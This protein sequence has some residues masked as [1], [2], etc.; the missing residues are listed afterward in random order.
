MEDTR[1][2]SVDSMTTMLATGVIAL[3]LLAPIS[4]QAASRK[5]NAGALFFQASNPYIEECQSLDKENP[6]RKVCSDGSI[7]YIQPPSADPNGGLCVSTALA[8]LL[9]NMGC[10]SRPT[11]YYVG[12]VDPDED[13]ANM[14]RVEVVADDVQHLHGCDL[15][16]DKTEATIKNIRYQLRTWIDQPRT[17]LDINPVVISL[18]A[19]GMRHAVTVVRVTDNTRRGCRVWVNHW[20]RQ[21]GVSCEIFRAWIDGR[22]MVFVAGRE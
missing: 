21:Y 10:V 14:R 18:R 1:R 2:T 20:G 11:D 7:S 15:D 3:T 4:S 13:G 19:P 22:D 16:F 8:N 12:R 6:Q 17:P 9:D 5:S